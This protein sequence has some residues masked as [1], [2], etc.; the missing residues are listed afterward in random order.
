M[1]WFNWTTEIEEQLAKRSKNQKTKL[2]ATSCGSNFDW[3]LK[4]QLP[5]TVVQ[6]NF[7]SLQTVQDR[8]TFS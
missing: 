5:E 2:D 3:S 4:P 1:N 6:T 7:S 8:G